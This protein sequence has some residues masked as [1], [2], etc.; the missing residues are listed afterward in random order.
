MNFS[1][2]TAR[3][4]IFGP[5]AVE[6]AAPAAARMGQ[7]ALI[8]TGRH[9]Q[10]AEILTRRLENAGV[11]WLWFKVE[12]EPEVAH[13]AC[14]A[15]LARESNC[16]LLIGF[17]GGS[18]LDGAKA[19]AALATNNAPIETYLEVIGRGQP[20]ER[21]PLPCI[22]VPTT[23]G[24]G[25]EVTRNAVLFSPAHQ[26][27][28]SLRSPMMLPEMAVVDP[29]LTLSLPPELTAAT[30]CDA[31]TQLLEAFVS[32]KATPLTDALCRDGLLRAARALPRAVAHGEDLNA[33]TEM[34]LAS[35]YSG[36]AL[37]NAGL[38][39]VH[40]IAG[41]LGGMISAPHGALC[42]RL[43]PFVVAANIRALQQ[44]KPQGDGLARYTEVAR[45]LTGS[46]KAE[47]ADGVAWLHELIRQLKI[48]TLS[49]WGLSAKPGAG[50]RRQS[51][52][53]QQHE[54]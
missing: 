16:D 48:P 43:L 19:I 51:Q 29:E 11:S 44:K 7:R 9:P 8:V 22:A 52:G 37:A 10:R 42:A 25:S 49:Q 24:T 41:P 26:V 30:G 18:A 12:G 1:F 15:D 45:L 27:K 32:A 13:M 14:G 6:Q 39:A 17:G 4:I 47:A 34:A 20:L 3:Q 35:L 28:V 40:G 31:L 50:N 46:V 53:G 36:M 5:G 54:R 33:R 21:P 38:G 23:A 2:A